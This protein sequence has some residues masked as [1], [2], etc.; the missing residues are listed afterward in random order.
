MGWHPF[1]ADVARKLLLNLSSPVLANIW[2]QLHAL[3]LEGVS[4]W[5]AGSVQTD[6]ALLAR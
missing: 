1:K 4:A 5:P 2:S 6:E 3:V